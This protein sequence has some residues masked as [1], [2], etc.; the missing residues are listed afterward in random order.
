MD[1]KHKGALTEIQA[2]AW[3]LEQG[4]DVFRNVS[5]HGSI[6][7]I[8]MKDGEV[9]YLDAKSAGKGY[10][11]NLTRAQVALGVKLITPA[12]CGGFKILTPAS[13]VDLKCPGC[14]KDFTPKRIDQTYCTSQCARAAGERRRRVPTGRPK[15]RPKKAV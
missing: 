8:A 11:S 10:A 3:L 4:Y 2:S 7:L 14:R 13:K 15:G 12:T 1:P 9:I 6:D 5:Q